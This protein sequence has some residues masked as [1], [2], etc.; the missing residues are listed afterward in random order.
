MKYSMI[1]S[2]GLVVLCGAPLSHA[3]AENKGLDALSLTLGGLDDLDPA[4]Y[5][6]KQR[7]EP[8]AVQSLSELDGIELDLLELAK[9]DFDL[10]V[11]VSPDIEPELRF[12]ALQEASYIILGRWGGE[13]VEPFLISELIR[14][15]LSYS[16]ERAILKGL[17]ALN[18]STQALD[19]LMRRV[20][21]NADRTSLVVDTWRVVLGQGTAMSKHALFDMLDAHGYKPE[22][23]LRLGT[24]FLQAQFAREGALSDDVWMRVVREASLVPKPSTVAEV[25]WP[26]LVL[27]EE[28]AR[29]RALSSAAS[30][31][32]PAVMQS[33]DR[34][35]RWQQRR[36]AR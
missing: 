3:H 9:R 12:A 18:L 14:E 20:V 21:P 4:H 11:W 8:T 30:S 28:N 36:Q 16:A 35:V 1:L 22:T 31:L 27:Q 33:I 24:H 23:N 25:L 5:F 15:D 10:V 13:G 7:P 19:V 29:D 32:G 17:A 34:R 6:K 2:I 26:L